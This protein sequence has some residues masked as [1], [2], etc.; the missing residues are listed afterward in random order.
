MHNKTVLNELTYLRIDYD[1]FM[2]LFE[3]IKAYT[4]TDRKSL[5][6]TTG[7][8]VYKLFEIKEKFNSKY[9]E[10]VGLQ[11]KLCS[12]LDEYF[13]DNK[14]S[15]GGY[16]GSTNL[17]INNYRIDTSFLVELT[18][19]EIFILYYY[20]NLF[21]EYNDMFKFYRSNIVINEIDN[22]LKKIQECI[23]TRIPSKV[24]FYNPYK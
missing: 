1:N 5:P 10:I 11:K 9:R 7:E 4:E 14:F 24:T 12:T 8:K 18:I 22:I 6:G 3:L 20:T 19:E 2:L 15:V 13:K 17:E 21:K 16:A 23:I